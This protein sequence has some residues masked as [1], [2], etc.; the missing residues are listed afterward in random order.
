MVGY[1]RLESLGS[2][3]LVAVVEDRRSLRGFDMGLRIVVLDQLPRLLQV[4]CLRRLQAGASFLGVGLSRAQQVQRGCML[5]VRNL[6]LPCFGELLKLVVREMSWYCFEKQGQLEVR[7]N[8]RYY[9]VTMELEGVMWSGNFEFGLAD[10]MGPQSLHFL[11]VGPP[12]SYRVGE[13]VEQLAH[14]EQ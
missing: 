14:P 6:M 2:S 10:R 8:Y 9:F 4:D 13:G 1:G 12:G 3:S 5:E 7:E 11:V